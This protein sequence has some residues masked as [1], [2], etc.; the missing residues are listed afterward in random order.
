VAIRPHIS[1]RTMSAITLSTITSVQ[2]ILF[3]IGEI[4]PLRYC[5]GTKGKLPLSFR[6]A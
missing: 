2:K 6:N 3:C 4:V 1:G 5:T